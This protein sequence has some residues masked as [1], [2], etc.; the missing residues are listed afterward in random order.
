ME[1]ENSDEWARAKNL[2][3]RLNK[4]ALDYGGTITGE[5][6]IGVGKREYMEAEHGEAY[7]LMRQIKATID[8]LGIMNP[9]KIFTT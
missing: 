4:L 2:S 6:G 3:S 8:P 1:P 7:A 9:G 5:H